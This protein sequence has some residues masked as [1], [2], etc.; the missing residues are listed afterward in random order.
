MAKKYKKSQQKTI[1]EIKDVLR[2]FA[3]GGFV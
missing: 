1:E 3:E 2:K